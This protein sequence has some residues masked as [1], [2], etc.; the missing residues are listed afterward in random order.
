MQ[1][2]FQRNV[3]RNPLRKTLLRLL[4]L[5]ALAL[6]LTHAPSALAADAGANLAMIA[7]PQTLDPMVTTIDLV[8]TIMQHVYETLYTFD[9]N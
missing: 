1:T 2:G 4:S 3:L 5:S 6:P 7:E 9:A 8:G